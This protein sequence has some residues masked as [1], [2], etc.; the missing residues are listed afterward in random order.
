MDVLRHT[1]VDVILTDLHMPIQ[2]GLELT[3]QV[4]A[5]SVNHDRRIIV[6]S[7]D[8]K[9]EAWPKCEAVGV[10]AYLEKPFSSKQLVAAIC[11]LTVT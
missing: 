5:S 6:L 4:R 9:H 1:K 10:N 11:E 2:G 7:A 3:K 8:N